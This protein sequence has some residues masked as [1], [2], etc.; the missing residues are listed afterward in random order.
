MTKHAT[1]STS[2]LWARFRFSVVGEKVL[3]LEQHLGYVHKGIERRFTELQPLQ[4]HRLA[5][6]VAL[7]L[8]GHPEIAAAGCG[9]A[10]LVAEGRTDIERIY[11]ID[12]GYETI[13]E[14]LSQLGARIR[15]V[16]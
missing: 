2:A 1:H 7:L 3:K 14:K 10:G 5:G 4:A 13:E 9:L 15:R 6:R 11:H 12:R 8:G 16:H